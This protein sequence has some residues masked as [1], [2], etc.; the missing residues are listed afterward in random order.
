MRK[1]LYRRAR[2]P[3]RL[4]GGRGV[5]GRRLP[6]AVIARA[7]ATEGGTLGE[8]IAWV[9]LTL[10]AIVVAFIVVPRV[11]REVMRGD[12]KDNDGRRS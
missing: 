3:R 5:G 1:S 11:V 12:R 2:L 9:M 4:R 7:Q 10:A 8:A 6:G